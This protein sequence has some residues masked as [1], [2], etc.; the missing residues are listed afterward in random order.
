MLTYH[1]IPGRF[2]P[3]NLDGT[4]TTLQGGKLM[5]TGPRDHPWVNDA[6]V[7]CGGITT[8]NAM[9]CL[10]DTVLTPPTGSCSVVVWHSTKLRFDHDGAPAE[11][12]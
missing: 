1:V 7:P 10:V 9:L 5:V 3:T 2:S 12:P 8:A 4:H 11:A 6:V